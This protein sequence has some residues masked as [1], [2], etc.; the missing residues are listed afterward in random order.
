MRILF[1]LLRN[2]FHT[3][4]E[5]SHVTFDLEEHAWMSVKIRI[6]R[7]HFVR[8]YTITGGKDWNEQR[9]TEQTLRFRFRTHTFPA[10]VDISP[11][12]GEGGNRNTRDKRRVRRP[13]W[14]AEGFTRMDTFD[15]HSPLYFRENNFYI[16]HSI[17]ETIDTTIYIALD[18]LLLSFD[19]VSSITNWKQTGRWRFQTR[20]EGDRGK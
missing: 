13:L 19:S 14:G 8:K 17:R 7:R 3:R 4:Y 15:H 5:I 18:S 6:H 16:R 1:I 20:F 11:L 10:P 9:T 2:T 12:G